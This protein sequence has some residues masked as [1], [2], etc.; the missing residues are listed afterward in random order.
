VNDEK[1][2]ESYAV[3]NRLNPSD[4]VKRLGLR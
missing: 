1:S 4:V 3:G 2:S